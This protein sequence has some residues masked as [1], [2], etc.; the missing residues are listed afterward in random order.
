MN[1]VKNMISPVSNSCLRI[2]VLG[3]IV[4]GPLG[5]MTW[6]ELQYILA[7]S[8]LGHDVYF[9]EDSDDYPSCYDPIRNIT[10]ID[11]TY[12]LTYLANI[13][14]KFG[15]TRKVARFSISPYLRVISFSPVCFT[16]TSL[17]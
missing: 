3:Y 13:L 11:P 14:K 7:F 1:G 6:S 4:R 8:R 9:I 16:M 12:G 10:D 5:G 2:I 17:S 15:M